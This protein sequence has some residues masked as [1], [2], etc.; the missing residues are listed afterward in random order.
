MKRQFHIGTGSL[1][2][3]ELLASY[4]QSKVSRMVSMLGNAPMQ[5]RLDLLA[6]T[7]GP[8]R[9]KGAA[10]GRNACTRGDRTLPGYGKYLTFGPAN[11]RAER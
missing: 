10:W 8:Y 2:R 11:V 1:H 6:Q 3:I 7:Q 5:G 4:R 9:Y